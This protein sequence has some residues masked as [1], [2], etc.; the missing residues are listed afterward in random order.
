MSQMRRKS[1]RD[2]FFF[3]F[4]TFIQSMLKVQSNVLSDFEAHPNSF[5]HIIGLLIRCWLTN[6]TLT[7]VKKFY[8]SVFFLLKINHRV[9]DIRLSSNSTFIKKL[10]QRQLKVSKLGRWQNT[11][12]YVSKLGCFLM[13]RTIFL[14]HSE[15]ENKGRRLSCCCVKAP[16]LELVCEKVIVIND[17]FIPL[18]SQF[19]QL[20]FHDVFYK[21]CNGFRQA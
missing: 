17:L 10:E 15:K 21:V 3:T 14:L 1:T 9:F 2:K 13:C 18:S 4:W 19:L 16:H 6:F 12:L 11:L 5:N 8:R 20:N 7:E